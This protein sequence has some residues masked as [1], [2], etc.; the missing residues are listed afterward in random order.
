MARFFSILVAASL[1]LT[2]CERKVEFART[3]LAEK[4]RHHAVVEVAS[5]TDGDTFRARL[6]DK[7]TV[8]IRLQGL[9]CPE[10]QRNSKCRSIE[11]KGGPTCDEQ[12]EMGH[13]ATRVALEL[14]AAG[15][16]VTLESAKRHGIL[17]TG[18]FGRRLAY[19]R[20]AD[21]RDF[22]L[23]MI[24]RTACKDFGYRYPHPRSEE[25]KRAE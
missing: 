9:D 15:S 22:G 23:E 13:E 5:V 7:S 16:R 4:P 1:M 2:A 10:V 20:L 11:E 17:P 24:R 8:P 12:I 6:R 3:P 19:V 18:G 21:G 14:L 25:Y